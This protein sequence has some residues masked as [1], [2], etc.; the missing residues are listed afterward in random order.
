MNT[1]NIE[2]ALMTT[3]LEDTTLAATL[4]SEYAYLR[5]VYLGCRRADCTE[6][7]LQLVDD[8]DNL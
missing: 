8:R 2:Q 1:Y 6:D 7:I 4:T 5:K 3:H